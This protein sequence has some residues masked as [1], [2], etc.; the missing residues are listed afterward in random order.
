MKQFRVVEQTRLD[1]KKV[2]VIQKRDIKSMALR[3]ISITILLISIFAY[4]WQ[5]KEDNINALGPVSV[6]LGLFCTL[7]SVL[8]PKTKIWKEQAIESTL[9]NAKS[10]ILSHGGGITK[11]KVVYYE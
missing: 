8:N 10:Y 5:I 9:D 6:T 1:N 7:S 4:S 11:S 2:Y 3:Y